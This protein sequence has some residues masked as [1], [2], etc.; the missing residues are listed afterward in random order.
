MIG[1]VDDLPPVDAYDTPTEDVTKARPRRRLD[2]AVHLPPQDLEAEEALLGAMLMGATALRAADEAGVEVDHFYRPGHRLIYEA[3]LAVRD[4]GAAV[5]ELTVVSKLRSMPAAHVVEGKKVETNALELVGGPAS[6]ISLAQRYVTVTNAPSY[7][8]AVI[9]AATK[10]RLVEAGHEVAR[11]GYDPTIEVDESVRAAEATLLEVVTAAGAKHERGDVADTEQSVDKWAAAYERRSNHE[12]LEQDTLSWG[13]V[14][15]DERLG[16]M[17]AGA[18]FVPAGWTKHGKTWFVLDVAEAVMEQGHRVLIDSMEMSDEELM[19]RFVAMGGHNLSN[20]EAGS[21][22]WSTLAP[23]RKQINGWQRRTLS[24]RGTVDRLR[25]QVSRAKLEG[26][27]YRLVVLDHLG[28]LRPGPGQG[29]QGRREFVEDAVAELKAMA[30]EYAFTLL[31]V[32]QLSRP[33][34]VKDAHERYLRPPIQS[35]LKEAS[36]IEQIATAVIFVYRRMKKDTGRF[37]GQ[38]AVLLMPFHRSK[39]PPEPLPCEFVLPGRPGTPSSIAYRFVP[40]L[41][42]E[43]KPTPEVAAVQT[44]IEGTFGPVSIAHHDNDGIP[45]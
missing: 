30:E 40:R 45:F 36:G 23:R 12:L 16:R 10:R 35:D 42:V 38:S 43:E 37:D 19:D 5:D 20:L 32:S 21:I 6:V 41:P 15:L 44:A 18:V 2:E 34:P 9:A 33:A 17:R 8:R 14:E 7:A 27:P 28:L 22:P 1:A 39:A 3:A 25:S 4:D 13:S 24:G 29:R 31:L 11:I 26:R